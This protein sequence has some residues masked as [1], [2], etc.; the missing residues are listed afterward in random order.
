M[1]GA[2]RLQPLSA[3][4]RRVCVCL[5]TLAAPLCFVGCADDALRSLGGGGA[6]NLQAPQPAASLS[7]IMGD[8]QVALRGATLAQPLTLIVRDVQG[9]AVAGVP[10]AFAITSGRATLSV[11]Q[12]LTNVAGM[13]S[14]GVNL[15]S[16]GAIAGAASIRGQ[17]VIPPVTF[18]FTAVESGETFLGVGAANV[19][20]AIT[21]L[22]TVIGGADN[23]ANPPALESGRREINWDAVLLDGTDFGASSTTLAPGTVVGIPTNRFQA[24]GVVFDRTTAVAGDGFV[25]VNP[26]AAGAFAPFSPSQVFAPF[27]SDHRVTTTFVRASAPSASPVPAKVA[28]FGA[29]FLDVERVGSSSVEYF[30]GPN[31]L[32]RFIVPAGPSGQPEFLGVHFAANVV[33]HVVLTVG[34]GA[35]FGYDNGVTTSGGADL[36]NG[37]A[38]DQ[39]ALDDFVYS[40]P[41]L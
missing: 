6:V 9:N 2:G 19:A 39:V 28:A 4:Y 25:S 17:S 37:G 15:S 7:V 36:S 27:G 20:A 12:G 3:R 23:G 16:V 1:F 11:E 14:T 33:T 32:G 35:L 22:A 8:Q 5:A 26:G 30:S 34:E 13:I 38:V 10:V 24:R 18:G 31:S 29:V 40:E 21:S 41:R